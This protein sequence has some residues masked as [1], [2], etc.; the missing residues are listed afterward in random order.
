VTPMLLA[1]MRPSLIPRCS[2]ETYD[3]TGIGQLLV[4]ALER[5]RSRGGRCR[6]DDVGAVVFTIR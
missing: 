5:S 1:R 6:V 2:N 4:W 3:Q